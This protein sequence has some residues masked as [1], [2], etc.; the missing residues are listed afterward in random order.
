[1]KPGAAEGWCVQGRATSVIARPSTLAG[2]SALAL[3]VLVSHDAFALK[4]SSSLSDFTKRRFGIYGAVSGQLENYDYRTDATTT[5]RRNFQTKFDINMKG[6]AWDPRLL[7]F[8]AGLSLQNENIRSDNGDTRFNTVGYRLQTTWFAGRPNPLN[9]FANRSKTT[10]ADYATP[11]YGLTTSTFGARWG[12]ED[13][14]LGRTQ[15]FLDRT[16][17]E[18]DNVLVPRSDTNL[19]LGVEAKQ[20]FRPKK[21]G[22]SELSYGY[23]YTSWDDQAYGNRQ[24]QNYF[25]GYDRT[26]FGE[27]V[28]LTANATYYNREDERTASVLGSGDAIKSDILNLS[29]ALQ[30]NESEVFQHHYS[31]G[32]GTSKVGETQSSSFNAN[33][34]ANYKLSE[35]WRTNASVG[36]NMSKVSGASNS[37]FSNPSASGALLYT[38]IFD[39]LMVNGGYSLTLSRPQTTEGGSFNNMSHSANIGYSRRGNTLY[40]DSLDLRTTIQTGQTRGNEQNIRYGVNSQLS[41]NDTLQTV[42]EYRRYRQEFTTGTTI[43]G[44]STSTAL[45]SNLL[46]FDANWMHNFGSTASTT[47]SAGGTRGQTQG[48]A[49]NLT[50]AQ[51]RMNAR[52][53]GNVQWTAM[54]R[55]ET[56]AGGMSS[57]IG[58]KT[59]LESDLN[60]RIGKWQTMARY[61]LR[62][63]RLE[64]GSF[65]E[66]SLLFFLKRDYAIAF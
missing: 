13:K 5:R 62:D 58:R 9:V 50:Y 37:T 26:L 41:N 30:V 53:P 17:S 55:V 48:F 6:F 45:D 22:E 8:D 52:L 36:W 46:R 47:V 35:Q 43:F 25:Y 15:F 40:A 61:R 2:V 21:W 60:Y 27:K 12:L 39:N 56:M 54:G 16:R 33:A 11:S 32:M 64:S 14:W 24:R 38:N 7:T 20:K 42:V 10:V 29:S 57:T 65:R 18:S 59:T 63:S 31:V 28:N 49:N 51:A 66:Q 44:A 34:G 23:R 4:V 19:N 1:M 3:L